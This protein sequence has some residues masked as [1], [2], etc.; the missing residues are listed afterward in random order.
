MHNAILQH[1]HYLLKVNYF[2]DFN[3]LNFIFIYAGIKFKSEHYV[4]RTSIYKDH[5]CIQSV[6]VRSSMW[7]LLY[8][9]SCIF[10]FSFYDGTLFCDDYIKESICKLLQKPKNDNIKYDT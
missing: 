10:S 1:I 7:S 2:E 3:L 5:L 6:F 4:T 8:R 9:F